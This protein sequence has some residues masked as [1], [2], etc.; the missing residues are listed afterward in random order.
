MARSDPPAKIAVEAGFK[1][2]G[3]ALPP[4]SH[5]LSRTKKNQSL[6]QDLAG[7]ECSGSQWLPLHSGPE[8]KLAAMC[9]SDRDVSLAQHVLCSERHW[10]A[11]ESLPEGLPS[12]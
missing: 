5:H 12:W 2:Q 3:L 8:S 7:V 1:L 4:H 11:L 10:A 9:V 6:E